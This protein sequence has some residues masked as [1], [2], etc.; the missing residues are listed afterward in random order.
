MLPQS[1][2]FNISNTAYSDLITNA[3]NIEWYSASTR[4]LTMKGQIYVVTSYLAANTF[5]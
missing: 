5:D 1:A 3:L 4:V 2:V